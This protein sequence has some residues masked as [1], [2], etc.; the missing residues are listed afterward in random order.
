MVE[1]CSLTWAKWCPIEDREVPYSEIKK[2]YEVEKDNYV[3]IEKE[4]L[5]KIKIKTTKSIDIKEFVDNKE[6]DPIFV[7]KSYYVAPDPKSA[8]DKAYSLLVKILK[9]SKRIAI[10]KVVLKD[11]ENLVA[12]RPYQRGIVMH[13]LK[14]LDEI[15]PLMKSQ[16]LPNQ[17][18]QSLI[19]KRYLW[20]NF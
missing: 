13:I 18:N 12:L 16:K 17:N 14:Y 2:G 5:D 7:D 20:V 4:D 15:R 1:V 9:D 3:I 19:L 10:G 6:L 11:R 8:N